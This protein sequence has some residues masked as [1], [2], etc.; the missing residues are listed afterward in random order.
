MKS[1]PVH[2]LDLAPFRL[3]DAADREAVARDLDAACRDSG[4]LLVTGHGVPGPTCD[5][6][7]DTFGEFFDLPLERKERFTV[8]D[9]TANRGYSGVGKEGLAY[10]RGYETPPD[11]FEAF[12]VGGEETVGPYFDA[13]REFYAPNV[14]PDRPVDLR[15][16]YLAYRA[17]REWRRRHPAPCDGARPRP[18]GVLVHGALR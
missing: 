8:R 12:N 1:L 7:L 16:T 17:R 2:A 9:D 5:A 10:S 18:A 15:R 4:F 13:H 14:W 6:M 3:G 11:L